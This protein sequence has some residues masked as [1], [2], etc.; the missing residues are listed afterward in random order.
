MRLCTV[1]TFLSLIEQCK[2]LF[3]KSPGSTTLAEN[4]IPTTG[5]LVK[6][7]PWRI[8]AN[9][10]QEVQKQIQTMLKDG[11]IEDKLRPMVGTCSVCQ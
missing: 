5:S 6:V 3:W 8:A 10:R 2:S 7:P 4:F 1:R 9:Y 11:V